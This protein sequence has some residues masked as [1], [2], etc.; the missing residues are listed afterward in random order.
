M[1]YFQ[2]G[3][4]FSGATTGLQ[5]ARGQYWI[6]P[7]PCANYWYGVGTSPLFRAQIRAE[8]SK[9]LVYALKEL[10]SILGS[11]HSICMHKVFVLLN[12]STL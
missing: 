10:R 9:L 4:C 1:L 3:C 7:P 8:V 12:G 6:R 5:H 11:H 2:S